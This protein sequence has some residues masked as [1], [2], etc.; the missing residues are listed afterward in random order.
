MFK[1]KDKVLKWYPQKETYETQ[2]KNS[3]E[4]KIYT[5]QHATPETVTL[6]GI[7][8]VVFN[9][10][11]EI[12]NLDSHKCPNKKVANRLTGSKSHVLWSEAMIVPA[13]TFAKDDCYDLEPV[14]TEHSD[15]MQ[16]Y[17]D[18]IYKW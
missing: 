13:E 12:L 14:T 16:N 2:N 1:H 11:G 10:K 17:E 7:P 4:P 5:V 15:V 8:Y 6:Y 9:K 18:K 3:L